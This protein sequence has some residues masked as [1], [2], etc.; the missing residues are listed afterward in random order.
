MD[1]KLE[2]TIA[3]GDD[4]IG[5]SI[6]D[7]VLVDV[8][9]GV[10][11]QFVVCAVLAVCKADSTGPEAADPERSLRLFAVLASWVVVVGTVEE[12]AR[13]DAEFF[14]VSADTVDPPDVRITGAVE[15]VEV[16][17]V[18]PCKASTWCGD[19]TATR[20]LGPG[21]KNAH[22]GGHCRMLRIFAG[23]FSD[24]TRRRIAAAVSK[25]AEAIP[26]KRL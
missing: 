14:V 16:D 19:H 11:D 12:V 2:I 18:E 13:V 15:V 9:S 21:P 26:S 10:V 17:E 3:T 23:L 5:E 20:R 24:R 4:D 22:C 1:Q 8:I 7:A 6:G 25:R